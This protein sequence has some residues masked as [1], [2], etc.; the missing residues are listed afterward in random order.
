[1][2]QDPSDVDQILRWRDRPS[3]GTSDEERAAA[4]VRDAL[5]PDALPAGLDDGELLAIEDRLRPE[6]RARPP[7]WLRPALVAALLSVSVASVMGYETG[8]FAPLRERLRFRAIPAVVPEA[9]P[10]PK[11][12]VTRLP[13]AEPPA[14]ES[15]P[16]P[17]GP[18][19]APPAPVAPEVKTVVT[20]PARKLAIAARAPVPPP[21]AERAP[22]LV[23]PPAAS[24]EILALQHAV[25]LLRGKHDAPAALAALDEYLGRYPNGVLAPEA[26]VAR[27]DALLMLDRAD[28]A[29]SALDQLPLDAHSRSTELQLIRGELR[30]RT[31]CSRAEPD[32]TAVLARV[33]TAPLE[34][35]ALY[36]RASCRSARG[37]TG[38][39]ASDLRAYVDRFPHGAH[40]EWARRWLENH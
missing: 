19:I 9:A 39:A 16:A 15:S 18:P 26:R 17:A 10:R 34:E 4:L 12:R 11:K 32:F 13:R 22:E 25:S 35:R 27:V 2:K 31:D 23:E 5:A 14:V 20:A 7:H 37:N 6:R 21:P 1:M 36:G 24:E 8:W 3:G 30:A 33:R 28:Q 38:G 40:A 29:L